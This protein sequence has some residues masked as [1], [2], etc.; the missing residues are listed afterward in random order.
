[1]FNSA[2]TATVKIQPA[3]DTPAAWDVIFEI[4]VILA[5]HIVLALAV[6]GLLQAFGEG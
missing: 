5:A 3:A 6:A 2:P 1:M 4:G